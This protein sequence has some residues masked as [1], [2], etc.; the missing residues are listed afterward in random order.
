MNL[1][2]PVG[3]DWVVNER[4]ICSYREKVSHAPRLKKNQSWV[5]VEEE[6][7]PLSVAL[8][9]NDCW[10]PVWQSHNE[11]LFLLNKQ[12]QNIW[13]DVLANLLQT[14]K[15]KSSDLAKLPREISAGHIFTSHA[16]YSHFPTFKHKQDTVQRNMLLYSHTWS[17]SW[18][19]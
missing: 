6:K 5:T 12:C 19:L 13:T 14:K 11:F 1:L 2:L 15:E 18:P 10:H 8:T 9:G 7:N 17:S 16:Q 3:R 4:E